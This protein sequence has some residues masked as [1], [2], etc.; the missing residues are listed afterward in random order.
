MVFFGSS[1]SG[2]RTEHQTP[3][4]RN[5]LNIRFTFSYLSIFVGAKQRQIITIIFFFSIYN[6][7]KCRQQLININ[8]SQCTVYSVYLL[9]DALGIF[10]FGFPFKFKRNNNNNNKNNMVNM[11]N[12]CRNISLFRLCG[13]RGCCC[14]CWWPNEMTGFNLPYVSCHSLFI[15]IFANNFNLKRAKA[16]YV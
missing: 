6:C 15:Y 1:G 16:I 5:T 9:D 3:T 7:Q 2:N 12:V 4:K 8:C 14:C 13:I 11:A 10:F